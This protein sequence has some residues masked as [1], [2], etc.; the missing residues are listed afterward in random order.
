MQRSSK[1]SVY[2][3]VAARRRPTG[4]EIIHDALGPQASSIGHSLKST[5][6]R[7]SYL[8]DI[9]SLRFSEAGFPWCVAMPEQSTR[10]AKIFSTR[11]KGPVKTHGTRQVRRFIAKCGI[12]AQRRLY[13][14]VAFVAAVVVGL[15]L[16]VPLC[17]CCHHLRC[18]VVTV[19]IRSLLQ[20]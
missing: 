13:N 1:S 5:D 6:R 4:S 12:G 7:I 8:E 10:I 16:F 19:A 3:A 14:S 15:L 11:D 20:L 9:S 17:C 2:R 18:R